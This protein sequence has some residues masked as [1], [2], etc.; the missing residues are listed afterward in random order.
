MSTS[1]NGPRARLARLA[2]SEDGVVAPLIGLMLLV[3]IGCVGLAVDTGR[4]VLVKARLSDAL[5]AAGLAVGARLST[6]D[7]NAD[8][9]RFVQANFAAGYSGATVTSVTATPNATKSV[10]T[11]SAEAEMPTAFMRI[12]GTK[13]VKVK[14]TSEVTRAATGLELVLA[15]DNTGSMSSSM[16]ALK[17][18][19]KSLLNILYG[20]QA[21]ADDLYVGLVP[22]SQTVNIGPAV[23]NHLA[24]MDP[25]PANVALKPS[26]WSGCIEARAYSANQRTRELDTT[27]APPTLTPLDK[28]TLFRYYKYPNLDP[29]SPWS[30]FFYEY[31]K[32]Y[33]KYCPSPMLP[34]TKKRATVETAIDNMKDGGNTHVNLGAV[35]GWRMLSPRWRG[36]WGGDMSLSGLPLDYNTPRMSKALVLMTDGANTMSAG[37]GGYTAYGVLSEKRL[38]TDQEAQAVKNLNARLTEVC[39]SAKSASVIIYTVAFNIP[40]NSEI[41][42]LM[43]ACASKAEYYFPAGNETALKD[44]FKT[45][46]DSLSNLRVSK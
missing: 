20:G 32:E 31:N 16:P 37:L 1:S 7:Y 21:E 41:E 23:A 10:I 36:K 15:L 9:K 5:D 19:A 38:G 6:T 39:N 33:N 17:S 45:I 44:A 14:A 26:G 46:G 40:K 4:G 34:M 25:D 13:L 42:K 35:W 2:R 8:A 24:W 43:Q 18:S 22:F 29:S 28:S 27:D 3:L 30:N 11:L 12:F